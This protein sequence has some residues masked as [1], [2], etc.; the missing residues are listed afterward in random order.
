MNF[1]GGQRMTWAYDPG[2]RRVRQVPEYGFDQP[3][4]GTD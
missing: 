3:L 1:A 4:G 2:I